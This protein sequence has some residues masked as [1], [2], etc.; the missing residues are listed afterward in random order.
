MKLE[1]RNIIMPLNHL[2]AIG[3]NSIPMKVLEL[4]NVLSQLPEL[5]NLSFSHAVFSLTLTT[6]TFL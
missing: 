4:I 6:P 2:K 1:L 5:F 3:T